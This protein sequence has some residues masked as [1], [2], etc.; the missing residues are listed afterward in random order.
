M[1]AGHDQVS[2]VGMIDEKLFIEVLNDNTNHALTLALPL[3]LR[4]IYQ[5]LKDR[6]R[7]QNPFEP[8]KTSRHRALC[9]VHVCVCEREGQ[10]VSNFVSRC[11]QI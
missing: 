8:G 10:G 11:A 6:E 7:F 3:L 4:Q 1:L 2:Q 5:F 9:A